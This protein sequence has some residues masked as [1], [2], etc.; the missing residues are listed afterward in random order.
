MMGN[1]DKSKTS[2]RTAQA[3]PLPEVSLWSAYLVMLAAENKKIKRRNKKKWDECEAA[4]KLDTKRSA[5]WQDSYKKAIRQRESKIKKLLDDYEALPLH[6][7]LVTDKP[8]I[9]LPYP[10]SF[11]PFTLHLYLPVTEPLLQPKYED[12]LTLISE[13]KLGLAQ[14][15]SKASEQV[16]PGKNA[17][18]ANR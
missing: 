16:K 17:K 4:Q 1:L 5:E 15:L 7:R 9:F 8:N 3:V 18:E 14:R 6:K 11:N 12:F 10:S 13:G 2:K